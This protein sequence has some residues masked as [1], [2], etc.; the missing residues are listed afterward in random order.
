MYA[1][2]TAQ[3]TSSRKPVEQLPDAVKREAVEAAR[4]AASAI[5]KAN[6]PR[7]QG[8]SAPSEKTDGKEA[9]IRNQGDQGKTQKALSPTDHGK[10]R[11]QSQERSRG[12]GMER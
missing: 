10:A 8:H 11:T 5:D 9:L 3:E 1:R 4:P 7:E 2:E 6:E 12:R